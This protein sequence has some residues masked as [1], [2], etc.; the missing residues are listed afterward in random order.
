MPSPLW[1]ACRAKRRRA[2]TLV[3][4]LVAMV[5]LVVLIGM[6]TQ[7][8]NGV[9]SVTGLGQARIDTDEQARALLDR[10]AIDI[11][12]MVKRPDVDY[13]LKGRP[14][15]LTQPGNDQIAFYSE[16]PGYFAASSATASST[17]APSSVSLIA[18]RINGNSL[19]MERM[20]KNLSWNGAASGSGPSMGFLPVPLASPLPSPLPSPT[21]TLD[22]LW[23]AAADPTAQDQ[24]YVEELGPQVFRFEYYYILKGPSGQSAQNAANS[25][26]LLS[27]IPWYVGA[28]L[29]HTSVNGMQDVAGVGVVIAVIDP[30]G[31][32][33]VPVS[34]LNVLIETMS[35]PVVDTS[36]GN[37]SISGQLVK[38]PGDIEA[39][40]AQVVNSSNL[41]RA[42]SSAIQIYTRCFYLNGVSP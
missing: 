36:T 41:P 16:T 8:T 33:L 11:G 40:W 26:N 34:K 28:P 32:A 14:T 23:P 38:S 7:M 5:V 2:F 31:R 39:Q 35:D 9:A 6:I 18:Y 30:K 17:P 21:M 15:T 10:M 13:Y 42:A 25:L 24:D 1:I 22:P 20:C 29:N 19:H 27:G 37:M 3:E 12:A 4:L